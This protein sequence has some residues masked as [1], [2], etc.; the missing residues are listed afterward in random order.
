MAYLSHIALGFIMAFLS[1]IPPGMLNMTVVKTSIQKGKNEGLWFALGAALVVI[2]QAFIALVFARYFAENPQVVER[3]ELA[4]IFVLFLLSGLFFWQAR[5]KFK[6]EGGK[7]EGKSFWLGM[8]MSGMNMLAIPFYLVLSSVLENRGLL[9]TEQP[10]IN[11]FVTGVFL[12]A[13]SLFFLYANFAQIIQRKAQFIA[14]NINYIL[15]A[16]F[17][18]LGILTLIKFLK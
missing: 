2:P 1:L 8:L 13:F 3:L 6:G 5:K 16:L 9:Q 15:S 12:G 18:V 14:R 11:L 10:F 17:L 7:R 4:G